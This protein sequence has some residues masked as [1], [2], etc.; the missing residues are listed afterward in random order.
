V[1]PQRT[2][3]SRTVNQP[4]YIRAYEQ[5]PV[6]SK[7]PGYLQAVNVDIGDRVSQGKVLAELWV[8]E[9]EVDVAQKKALVGQAKAEL[10][11]ST[12]AVLVAEADLRS[13]QAK[14]E[15]ARATLVRARAQLQR[16]QSQYAR[17]KKAG[18]GQGGVIGQEDVEEARL[19]FEAAQAGLKE[20]EAQIQSAQ[21]NRD[22]SQARRDKA[23]VDVTVA[24]AHLE[25]AKK[26]RQQ[27]ETMLAYS[28]ITA[29][30]KGV[31]TQRN[32]DTGHFVQPA[33]TAKGAA[34][35]TV[36][37]TDR[38]RIRVEVP[39]TEADWVRKGSPVK[40]RVQVLKG[41]EYVG[42]VTRTSWS[43]DPTARTLLAEVDV[44]D[45]DGKLRPGMYAYAT[46]TAEHKNVWTL[47]A[48]AVLTEGEVTQGYRSYCF[49]VEDG[50]LR[51]T[52]LEVGA[53]NKDLV[54]VLK[55]GAKPARPGEKGPWEDFT[56]KEEVVQGNLSEL[57][58]GQT[59]RVTAAKH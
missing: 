29:P 51:R 47:P 42:E 56:G 27:A 15:A 6:F 43:V 55:K 34:L 40:V 11:Q 18:P 52:P 9:M 1:K 44:S 57:H 48:S 14:V 54:E 38:L 12:Q 19:G 35:F 17:L 23:K 58:D 32:V 53:R 8:P 46:I 2:T 30:F 16:T 20:V 45:P 3:L 28:K 26:N 25:V 39:E 36:M 37:R 41:F 59:V 22:A 33:T 4:G 10:D 31:V 49:L 5:T 13:A 24:D 21:A 50:K 7:I